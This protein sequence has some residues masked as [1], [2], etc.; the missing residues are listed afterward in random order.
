MALVGCIVGCVA[1]TSG[2]HFLHSDY[3]QRGVDTI[4]ILPIADQRLNKEDQADLSEAV[5]PHVVVGV[6]RKDYFVDAKELLTED[7]EAIEATARNMTAPTPEWLSEIAPEGAD[8][9]LVVAVKRLQTRVTLRVQSEADLSASLF[10]LSSGELLWHDSSTSWTNAGV[11]IG[12]LADDM[13]LETAATALMRSL[14]NRIP[15]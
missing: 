14:P 5:I 1:P 4:T 8:W 11:L 13:A 6:M 9:L 10:D 2:T 3:S 15:R 12:P 7:A